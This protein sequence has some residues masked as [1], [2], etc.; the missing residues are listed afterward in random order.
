MSGNGL[1]VAGGIAKKVAKKGNTGVS[2]ERILMKSRSPQAASL[3]GQPPVAPGV[4]Q[5]ANAQLDDRKSTTAYGRAASLLTAALCPPSCLP[6]PVFHLLM[7]A[8]LEFHKSKGQH[9]LKN[10]LVVQ[11]IVDKAGVKG[12]DVV[13]EIGP[14][15]GQQSPVGVSCSPLIQL[16]QQ[17]ALFDSYCRQCK[18]SAADQGLCLQCCDVANA[19]VWLAKGISW[20]RVRSGV[21]TSAVFLP[22]SCR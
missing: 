19:T 16:D 9:I 20:C 5:T 14:G 1:R 21:A 15:T 13:L 7:F 8:G 4:V 12:T 2:G 22:M 10:P 3:A 18:M 11:S 17:P 6:C